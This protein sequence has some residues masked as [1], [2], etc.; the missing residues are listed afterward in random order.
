[1]GFLILL[2]HLLHMAAC[3]MPPRLWP[4]WISPEAVPGRE[5]YFPRD[6]QSLKDGRGRGRIMHT[7]LSGQG[8]KGS[9]VVNPRGSKMDQGTGRG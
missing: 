1:M 7:L 9:Q 4:G 3:P 2:P 5:S 6:R 8:V